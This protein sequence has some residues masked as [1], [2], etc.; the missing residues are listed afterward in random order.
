MTQQ[1][2]WRISS[3]L[4]V[5]DD[6]LAVDHYGLVAL[7]TLHAAPFATREIVDDFHRKDLQVVEI[8]VFLSLVLN[9][10]QGYFTIHNH[11]QM[12]QIQVQEGQR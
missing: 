5:F 7:G 10:V 8:V 11:N 6:R 3:L 12:N 2:S 9:V 1:A 4:I